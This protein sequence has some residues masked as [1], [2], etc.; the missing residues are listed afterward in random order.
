LNRNSLAF[1][2]EGEFDS[3]IMTPDKR[4][5]PP[6][7]NNSKANVSFRSERATTRATSPVTEIG[8]RE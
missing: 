8:M 6:S 3:E 7:R 1:A 5:I 2:A 4:P